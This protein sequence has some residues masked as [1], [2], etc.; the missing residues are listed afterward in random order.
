VKLAA[1]AALAA[2][3]A[4][5]LAE[6]KNPEPKRPPKREVPDYDGRAGE[7]VTLLD[8][9][10]WVPRVV[11]FVPRV[12]IDYGVRWPI[13]KLVQKAEHS[14]GFRR[15]VHDFF[16]EVENANPLIFP[17]V[18][19]DFGFKPSVGARI[20]WRRGYLVPN[21]DVTVRAGTGGTD[22]WRADAGIKSKFGALRTTATAGANDR[23]DYL[24]YGVGR[25]T[26]SEAKARYS[27]RKLFA[28]GSIGGHLEGIGEA[29]LTFGVGDTELGESHYGDEKSIEEQV[30]AGNIAAIPAGYEDDY[31]TARV[32]TR[33]TLD[34][35]FDGK[36]ARS[37]VRFD[38]GVDRVYN[39]TTDVAWTKFELVLGGS[40]LLDPVAER[41]LD[42]RLGVEFIEPDHD[43]DVIPF[44][45]LPTIAGGNW[46][47]GLS[48]GRL[49]GESAFAFLL[50]YNWPLAAWLDAH[51]NL[52]VGNVFDDQL[53]GFSLGALRGSFGGS[54][55]IAG[56]SERQIGASLHFG[57]EPLGQGG[58]S[59][60]E[61]D[62]DVSNYRLI[63]EYSGDY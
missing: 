36:R 31:R 46:L 61:F 21:S 25:D 18:L 57:T 52:G 54:L 23:P 59:G 50:D 10:L 39:T 44:P 51:A 20:L 24:F 63:L 35:R 19:V 3:V 30:A 29:G 34:S 62:F 49:Y 37:G 8:G 17:V 42:V 12:V 4:P 32:G 13:G 45:E 11:L 5:V 53:D 14:K 47:R 55:T 28:R 15:F 7:P 26:P 16:R 58:E 22:W 9:L 56:L 48:P 2:L 40:V 60:R 33:I 27:A 38:V 43:M 41:K 1:V 6:D